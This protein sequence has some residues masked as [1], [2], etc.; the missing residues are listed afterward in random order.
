MDKLIENTNYQMKQEEIE[1]LNRPTTSKKT[2]SVIKNLW[3]K[4]IP[5]LD[6]FLWEFYQTFKELIP[7]LLKLLQKIEMEGK[8]PKSFYEATITLIPKPDKDLPKKRITDPYPWWTQMWKFSPKY[9]P[10]GSNSTLKGLFTM[11]KWGLF[12]GPKGYLTFANQSMWYNILI[13]ER[14]RIVWYSQ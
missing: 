5:G 2:E 11:T 4:R 10:I 6:G 13:K 12:L 9:W 1:N 8:L 7:I 3:T 14:T